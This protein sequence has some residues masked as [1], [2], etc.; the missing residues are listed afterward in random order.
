MKSDKFCEVLREVCWKAG[1]LPDQMPL[2]REVESWNENVMTDENGQ[3]L[4]ILYLMEVLEEDETCI[5]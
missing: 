3:A 2:S 5:H 4:I 1:F